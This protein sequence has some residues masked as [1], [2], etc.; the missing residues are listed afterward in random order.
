MGTMTLTEDLRSLGFDGNPLGHAAADEIEQLTAKV[1]Q[2]TT[3]L[4]VLAVRI[5]E[6]DEIIERLQA[7]N[8]RLTKLAAEMNAEL[9]RIATDDWGKGG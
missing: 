8:E 1:E 7:E 2:K 4:A 9:I 3:D 5:V 6:R